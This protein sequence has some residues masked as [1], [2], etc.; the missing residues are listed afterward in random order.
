[1]KT[2]VLALTLSLACAAETIDAFGLKWDVPMASE[3]SFENGVLKILKARPQE[4]NPRRPV[5]FAFG[6]Q[7]ST[8][9]I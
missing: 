7:V 3:G 4:K 2:I 1:M 6:S 5:Q 8:L 9:F